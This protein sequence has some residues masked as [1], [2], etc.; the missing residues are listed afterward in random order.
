M[1]NMVPSLSLLVWYIF[2]C[3]LFAVLHVLLLIVNIRIHY[4]FIFIFLKICY[5]YTFQT[6]MDV[7]CIIEVTSSNKMNLH[8]THALFS[9]DFNHQYERKIDR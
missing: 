4:L 5:S 8:L 9:I 2:Q 7:L 6:K 3:A 1:L